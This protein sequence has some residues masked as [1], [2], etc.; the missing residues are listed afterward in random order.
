VN[1][2]HEDR[3]HGRA[4][5]RCY[6]QRFDKDDVIPIQIY[7]DTTGAPVMKTY[8]GATEIEEIVGVL[9]NSYGDERF[10]YNYEITFDSDYYDKTIKI[11]V[12][13]EDDT[14]TSE[15]ILIEELNNE[16]N[17][18]RLKIIHYTNYDRYLGELDSYF[19][20]WESLSSPMYFYVEATDREVKDNDET[21]NLK[22]AQNM[23]IVSASLFPGVNLK[24]GGIPMYMV[25][26][27]EAVS[28]LD[29][30]TINEVEYVKEGRLDATLFGNTTS[31]QTSA[32]LIEKNTLGI[33]IDDMG[34]TCCDEKEWIKWESVKNAI[35]NF[36]VAIP[37]GYMLHAIL[38][39]HAATSSGNP[40]TVT[41]GTTLGGTD[42]FD[43]EG[44]YI[45]TVGKT[46]SFGIHDRP[47]LTAASTLYV[48][49]SGAAVVLDVYI[50]F[51]RN[52]EFD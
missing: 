45:D 28:S 27:L 6:S 2:L 44:G 3:Y 7:S 47:S 29:Y 48:G 40:A 42:Y 49:I 52:E 12:T 43:G 10:F 23:Y 20:D 16:I 24:T 41:A 9:G 35:T 1:T 4:A 39:R 17:K 11:V 30:F 8:S 34:L 50:D 22:G 5:I 15:P 37:D 32:K 38:V 18:G 46:Y 14:L 13:K 25:R 21:E 31:F 36:N 19:M 51:I 26:R 33:N